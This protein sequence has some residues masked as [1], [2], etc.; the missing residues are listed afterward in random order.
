MDTLTIKVWN[1]AGQHRTLGS[2]S[3]STILPRRGSMGRA[4]RRLDTHC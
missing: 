4:T 2:V 3:G 1:R